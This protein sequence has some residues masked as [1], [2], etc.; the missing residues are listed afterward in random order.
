MKMT[1]KNNGR[2]I[3]MTGLIFGQ[4]TVIDY[5][6]GSKWKCLCSC[7]K[8][9]IVAGTTLRNGTSTKCR[10]C[11]CAELN[12][13]TKI[14]NKNNISHGKSNTR[15]YRIWCGIISRCENPHDTG[16]KNYGERGIHMCAEWRRDFLSFERWALANGYT[17]QLS[18]DR[19]N[20]D[21][22]YEPANCRWVTTQEQS[23]NKTTNRFLI[24]RGEKKT[25]AQWAEITQI[26]RNTIK[27]R[28][29]RC[30]WSIE[31]AL[32]VPIRGGDAQCKQEK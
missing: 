1:G 6:G 27:N 20:V 32:T 29:D 14:G 15:I 21:G 17:D 10:S 19:I 9:A 3:D 8:T 2:F 5:V 16:Y 28:I 4:W 23:N 13:T 26:P 18:I 31:R 12:R 7:G 22:A 11:A 30:G 25:I 24:F